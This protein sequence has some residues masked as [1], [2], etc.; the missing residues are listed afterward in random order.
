MNR[1]FIIISFILLTVIASNVVANDSARIVRVK[2]GDTYV[3]RKGNKDF[4]VR[5]KNV[6]SPELK[7][8]FGY[9]SFVFTSKLISGK[10][11]SLKA[12]QKFLFSQDKNY[13]RRLV[14]RQLSV[15]R[16]QV[17]YTYILL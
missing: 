3:L 14:E 9:L 6:D 16:G 2:D 11:V 12:G 17:I 13:E 15:M 7:Q 10:T 1:I 4:T 8:P 5:L